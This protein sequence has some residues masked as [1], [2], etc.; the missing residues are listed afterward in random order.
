MSDQD[1]KPTSASKNK[2]N[3]E[4]LDRSVIPIEDAL[5][6]TFRRLWIF[7]KKQE[8]RS[9]L[10]L[11][12]F[13][14][15]LNEIDQWVLIEDQEWN[16]YIRRHYAHLFNKERRVNEE[17]DEPFERD[18]SI[19]SE[20]VPVDLHENIGLRTKSF[21]KYEKEDEDELSHDSTSLDPEATLSQ[22]LGLRYNTPPTRYKI[23]QEL[24]RGG[25]G[26][27]MRARDRQLNRDLVMK[28]LNQG[29]DASDR[30]MLNFIREAKITAQLEHPN[31]I[32]IHDLS[33][34]AHGEVIFTM[35]RIRG[36]TLKEIIRALRQGDFE[37]KKRYKRIQLLDVFKKVC[38]AVDFAHSRGVLHRDLKP[39]NIMVGEYGEVLVLDWGIAKVVQGDFVVHPIRIKEGDGI[40]RSAVVGTPSYMPP[41]QA[42]GQ[43]GR[44][45]PRSD[46]Y[47]LG[48][49][50]YEILS[51]RPPF[52]GRDPKKILNE[53]ISSF[54]LSPRE[55]KP[56]LK[57]P[58]TLNDIAMKCLSKV[59]SKRFQTV[60]SLYQAVDDYLSRLEEFD[61][62]Y[63]LSDQAYID[64]IPLLEE[65]DRQQRNFNEVEAELLEL[66]WSVHPLASPQ[67]RQLI[68]KAYKEYRRSLLAKGKALRAVERCLYSALQFYNEH[69]KA[70]KDLAYLYSLRLEEA[71]ANQEQ[72]ERLHYQAL[73]KIYNQG[74]F[75]EL[76]NETGHLQ[77]RSNPN[78]AQVFATQLTS[79]HFQLLTL[80]E[81]SWG[82]TPLNKKHIPQGRWHIRIESPGKVPLLY[83]INLKRNE[84]IDLDAH[85]LEE[86]QIASGFKCIPAGYLTMK[87]QH[88]FGGSKEKQVWVDTFAIR[89]YPVTCGEYLRFL[90]ILA[91]SHPQEAQK[92]VPRINGLNIPLWS[93]NEQGQYQLPKPTPTFA[94][95]SK[96]PIFGISF[97]DAQMF[98]IW[99]A[100]QT[101]LPLRLPTEEE[102]EKAASGGDQRVFPWGDEFDP[103]F[104]KT[105][106]G[107]NKT[108]SPCDVGTFVQDQSPHGLLDVVG[109]VSEFC[110]ANFIMG[111]QSLKV[112]KGG[113]F[114]S[115][116]EVLCQISNRQGVSSSQPMYNVGFRLAYDFKS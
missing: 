112:A 10:T 54:P 103:S 60:S 25:V 77:I 5:R 104:C 35:K 1:H 73:L 8:L 62:N 37:T 116:H 114:M 61:R 106:I 99:C 85:L 94:W 68:W 59:R 67:Q 81:V 23:G 71:E 50:L 76:L 80:K 92:R 93:T 45:D 63:K 100:R 9:L 46:I 34:L 105:G 16:T 58:R 74:D 29:S 53:V 57:I 40:E 42:K 11:A 109:N 72:V 6:H 66:Q 14:L 82:E 69:S 89:K 26:R 32:P 56:E 65:Y 75:D 3:S 43:G 20:V 111:D 4:S 24:A 27:V 17:L 44:V 12:Q 97:E 113:H 84:I 110:D 51:Y 52:R 70:R 108:F 39:S 55:F 31:I 98:C 115:M 107:Q 90:N 64:S 15:D 47:S 83:C 79:H 48:A 19:E 96:W 2:E 87:E 102:W 88:H 18:P 38:Q 86:S 101:Q 7:G 95:S 91:I 30:V 78:Q 13:P 49:I 33:V 41:E 21:Q 28:G 36:Q 22:R